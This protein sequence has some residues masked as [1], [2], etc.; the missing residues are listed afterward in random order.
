[1]KVIK[2]RDFSEFVNALIRN[3]PRT[4]VGVQA[5]GG[6]FAFDTLSSAEDL[7]LGYD[8][9]TLP[10]KKYFQPQ[11]E[12]IQKYKLFSGYQ[13][14]DVVQLEPLI[15]VGIHPYDLVAIEQMDKIFADTN[16]DER[17]LK[18]R[19]ASVLIGVN[20]QEASPWAFADS[21]GTAITES[22][23]DLMLT[24]LGD[25]KYAVEVGSDKGSDLLEKCKDVIEGGKKEERRLEEIKAH[26]PNMFKKKLDFSP[27]ELPKYLE[28]AHDVMDYWDN[29]AE[30]CYS[31][32]SCNLVCPTCYCFDV[33]DFVSLPLKSG[34]RIRVWDG[35]LLEEF[36][37]VASGENFRG[38]KGE[39]Y[40]HRYMRKGRYISEKFGFIACVG[41]GRCGSHCLPDIADPTRIFNGLKEVA[42]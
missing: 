9:T 19:A 21:M 26:I 29:N 33:V 13:V 17:Y 7:R 20:I 34:E 40:R 16:P 37:K 15:I 27:S 41:C 22:G 32:G 39:R 14:E 6:K 31:C 36:A 3:D 35:C 10:P 30:K 1:M 38:T 4:V 28:A 2:K 12:S 25:N 5:R 23:Y 8:V 11:R 42:K 24:D 18:R